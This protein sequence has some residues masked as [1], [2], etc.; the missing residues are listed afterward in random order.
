MTYE[1]YMRNRENRLRI[2]NQGNC[3]CNPQDRNSDGL[4]NFPPRECPAQVRA[5]GEVNANLC[6]GCSNGG[7]TLLFESAA[8]GSFLATTI[9]RRMAF[10]SIQNKLTVTGIGFYFDAVTR[11]VP[12][13]VATFSPGENKISFILYF[14][15]GEA[16][17]E[18]NQSS[19]ITPCPLPSS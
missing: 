15:T 18:F 10:D 17:L 3:G 1:N 19:T 12:N 5:T 14:Q 16:R 8:A 7:S 6:P 11:F 4:G 2:H 13:F 9:N